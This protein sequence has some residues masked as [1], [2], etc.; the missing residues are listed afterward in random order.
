MKNQRYNADIKYIEP[1]DRESPLIYMTAEKAGYMLDQLVN[2]FMYDV[3]GALDLICRSGYD[4][5]WREDDPR[6]FSSRFPDE[7][8][9]AIVKTDGK[10]HY[11]EKPDFSYGIW[12]EYW[13]GWMLTFVMDATSWTLP[14]IL[15]AVSGRELEN[16]Y[17]PYH[18]MDVSKAIREV[19]RRV[20]DYYCE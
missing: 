4:E 12:S 15:E 2:G 10:N 9:N 6:K 7:I 16:M 3:D 13:T 11:D 14:Y 8:V 5:L 19:I 1:V 18:E 17:W 20:K